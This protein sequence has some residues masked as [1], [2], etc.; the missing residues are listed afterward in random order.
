M[1][2]AHNIKFIYDKINFNF[3]CKGILF[4]FF[5][6]HT[7]YFILNEFESLSYIYV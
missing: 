1:I 6:S 5:Y 3:V 2:C 4:Y 7:E